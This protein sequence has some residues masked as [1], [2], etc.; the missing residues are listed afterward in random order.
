MCK[1]LD[2]K[3]L[4]GP[5]VIRSFESFSSTLCEMGERNPLSLALFTEDSSG[6]DL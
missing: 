6:V 1:F 4:Q 3:P 5:V 2:D